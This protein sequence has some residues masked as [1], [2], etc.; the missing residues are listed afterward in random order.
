VLSCRRAKWLNV[1]IFEKSCSPAVGQSAELREFSPTL[2]TPAGKLHSLQPRIYSPRATFP[3]DT[4][5]SE[6]SLF[7]KNAAES[8]AKEEHWDVLWVSMMPAVRDLGGFASVG[9]RNNFATTLPKHFFDAVMLDARPG[10]TAT[11]RGRVPKSSKRGKLNDPANCFRVTPQILM[12]PTRHRLGRFFPQLNDRAKQTGLRALSTTWRS[13][14]GSAVFSA[15][16]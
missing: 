3:D 2:A 5:P 14:L 9:R 1:Q 15:A 4:R 6:T 7:H 10:I 12:G 16:K 13:F 11:I 8:R